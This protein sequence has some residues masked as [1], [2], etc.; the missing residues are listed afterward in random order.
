M[1]KNNPQV[2][3]NAYTCQ[4]CIKMS[5]GVKLDILAFIPHIFILDNF[6]CQHMPPIFL[7]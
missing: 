1:S 6:D 5:F 3:H 7:V 2:I 4:T